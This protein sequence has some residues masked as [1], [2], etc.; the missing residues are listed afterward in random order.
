MF[1]FLSS[2]PLVS[3]FFI[4]LSVLPSFACVSMVTLVLFVLRVGAVDTRAVTAFLKKLTEKNTMSPVNCHSTTTL[5]VILYSSGFFFL[6]FTD[7]ILFLS[8]T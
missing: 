8:F 3:L 5:P 1:R 7:E 4:S 2:S 6:L